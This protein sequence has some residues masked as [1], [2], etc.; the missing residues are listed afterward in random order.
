MLNVVSLKEAEK[1]I[2]ENRLSFVAEPENVKL[3]EC[4]GRI[5]YE[6]IYSAENIPAFNRSTVDGFAVKATDTYGASESIP[7]QLTVKGEIL[8]GEEA[9]ISLCDGECIRISTGGM[10]PEGADAVVMV[11]NTDCT[12]DDFCLCFKAVSPFENVTRK[13]DDL[14]EKSLILTKGTVLS[15]KHTGVLAALGIGTV[16][17]AKKIRVGIVSTGDELVEIEEK[18]TVGKIRDINTH[19]LM[20]LITEMGCVAESYGIIGD[21]FQEIYSAVKKSA[22]ENDIVLISGGSSAGVKDMT[23]KVISELGKVHFHGI[24]LKPGKPTIY[25]TVDGKAVFGLP[26]NPAAAYYVT[27]L[28]VKPLI[29]R[30]YEEKKKHRTVCAKISRNISSNHGREEVISVKLKDGKAEPLYAKSAFVGTLAESDGY[31]I[32]ERDREG[33]KENEEVT[34]YIN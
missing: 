11:E 33:L 16:K 30:L 9:K 29:E 17:V 7:A 15:A 2:S 26:G 28:T 1:I 31:I 22:E 13:G 25:G 6:D 20:S 34:V 10:L 3:S 18:L 5:L 12:F 27:L 32:I 8:M 19:L 14:K 23:V 21:S 4:L 24:A